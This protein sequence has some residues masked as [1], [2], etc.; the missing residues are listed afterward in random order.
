MDEGPARMGSLIGH[1]TRRFCNP[2]ESSPA[3]VLEA[4]A[5]TG[6]FPLLLQRVVRT[7]ADLRRE[8]DFV[9]KREERP[10]SQTCE[11]SIPKN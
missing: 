7:P 11:C 1:L 3:I 10:L 8:L 6:F 9:S 5:A 4:L 2:A